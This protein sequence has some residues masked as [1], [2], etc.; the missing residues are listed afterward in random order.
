MI[1][2]LSGLPTIDYWLEQDVVAL[3]PEDHEQVFYL[4]NLLMEPALTKNEIMETID[5]IAF[6]AKNKNKYEFDSVLLSSESAWTTSTE[7]DYWVGKVKEIYLP[8]G[9]ALVRMSA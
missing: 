7:I 1:L 6:V 2:N 3:A 4:R 5:S 8:V 9:H